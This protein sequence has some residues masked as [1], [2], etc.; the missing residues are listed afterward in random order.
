MVNQILDVNVSKIKLKSNETLERHKA[1]LV[2]KGYTQKERFDYQ[3]TFSPIAKLTTVRLF[4]ALA[5]IY[6]WDL[7]QLD[8][9][10][11]FLNGDLNE[12]IYMNLLPGYQ[13]KES[14]P[15]NSELICKLLKSLY[16]LKQA[17]HQWYSK[18]SSSLI[19]S[20]FPA[21]KIGLFIVHMGCEIKICGTISVC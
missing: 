14:H 9:H 4:L 10:N 12:E 13:I 6:K 2:A 5:T 1:R 15:K 8:A 21:I 3:E 17:S 19:S 18:F 11:A 20:W 16:G 7:Y